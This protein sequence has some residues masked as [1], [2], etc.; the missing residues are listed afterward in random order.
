MKL[1]RKKESG[2]AMIMALIMLAL[3]GLLVAPALN[4]A[5]TSVRYHGLIESRTME[6]Y[7]ADS[8]V[9]YALAKLRND[10]STDNFTDNFTLNGRTVSVTAEDMGSNLHKITATATSAGGRS[11]TIESYFRTLSI[12]SEHVVI[13]NGDVDI[14]N[15]VIIAEDGQG[16]RV[17]GEANMHSNADFAITGSELDGHITY[18]GDLSGSPGQY[19]SETRVEEVKELPPIDTVFWENEAKATG[20]ISYEDVEIRDEDAYP[21]GPL[22]IYGNLSIEKSEVILTGTVYVTGFIDVKTDSTIT[23]AETLLAEG[24]VGIKSTNYDPAS[25]PLIMSVNGGIE[26]KSDSWVG[27]LLYAPNGTIDLKGGP[28]NRLY[29]S[30]VGNEVIIKGTTVT[31]I[32]DIPDPEDLPGGEVIVITYGYGP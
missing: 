11:T 5:L 4:L 17:E 31:Y 13:S 14:N 1:L 9:Q 2:Q 25:I 6:S 26:C 10:P 20:N 19:I 27:A 16:E 21:L 15:S 7:A 32:I 18:V 30:V 29:G 12:F 22:F 23:G 3:G 24:D 28:D 8:G